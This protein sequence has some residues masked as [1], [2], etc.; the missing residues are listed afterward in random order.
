MDVR[1]VSGDD[2]AARRL[3]GEYLE[4]IERRLGRPL[5]PSEYPGADAGELEPPAGRLLIA[6]DGGDA[7]ACGAVRVIAPGIAEVK[8][9]YVAP[10]ARGRGLGRTLLHRLERCAVEL[11]CRTVRLDT[12]AA[13][14][15]AAG[16]YRSAGYEP[17]ADY[18]GNPLAGVWMERTLS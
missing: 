14:A 10:Q 4:E 2:E 13:M 16:L 18:N 1:A 6:F 8:R 12:M 17:I 15:E 7:V 3:L 9:M 11:G 5:E